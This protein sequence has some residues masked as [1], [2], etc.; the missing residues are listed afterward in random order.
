MWVELVLA[1]IIEGYRELME[2]WQTRTFLRPRYLAPENRPGT[3]SSDSV[4]RALAPTAGR[5][6]LVEDSVDEILGRHAR[7]HVGIALGVWW[8]G[9]TWMFG[10]GRVGPSRPGPPAA[11]T[12]FEIGSVTK[13][14]TAT[15]LADMVE[16]GVVALNDPVRRY[17]PEGVELP[18]RGRPVTLADLATHTSGL[19]RLPKGLVRRSLRQRR[20]PYA[21]FTETDLLR[22]TVRGRL[23]NSPGEK[24]RYSNFGYGLLGYALARHASQT[25]EQLVRERVCDPAGLDDAR[26]AFSPEA[27][28]RFA[29]GHNRRGVAVPPWDL[30]ALAGAGALRSTLADLLRFIDIQLQ[31]PATRLGRAVRAT[32]EPRAHRGPLSQG[33]G[34]GRLPLRNGSHQ[35]LWHNGGTG[36]FRSFIGFIQE[37]EVGVIVLSNCSRSVDAVGF[38][39]L[40]AIS[41]APVR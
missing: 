1:L 10:R 4:D 36:G 39:M 9:E 12:I 8:H 37:T 30:A 25:F 26:I 31:P 14:F 35:M 19:P 33:L 38:R 22:A 21:G 28:S 18:V 16:E 15:V 7:K 3:P 32:H 24:L 6:R 27:R 2:W 34:W 13:V 41:A 29:D 20:N 40:E 23:R 17:L 11:D 5:A